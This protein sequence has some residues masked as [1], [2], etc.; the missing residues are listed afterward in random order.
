MG[1]LRDAAYE[2]I[3]EKIICC[4]YAPGSFISEAQVMT[5]LDMS[6]TPIREAFNKLEQEGLLLILPK[7]GV[8]VST[9]TMTDISETFEVRRMLEPYLVKNYLQNIDPEEVKKL[10][11][12]TLK[13]LQQEDMPAEDFFLLDDRLHQLIGASCGN[14]Y[15]RS[16]LGRIYAQNRRLRILL[17]QGA[18][19]RQSAVEHLD[20]LEHILAG[21]AAEAEKSL[22]QHLDHSKDNALRSLNRAAIPFR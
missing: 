8:Q 5:E 15:I 18:R 12:E 11:T 17:G 3:R 19:Y 2:A 16:M 1:N 10:R 7:R 21:D 20:I 13:L 9:M 22:R 14:S 6:R 4:A